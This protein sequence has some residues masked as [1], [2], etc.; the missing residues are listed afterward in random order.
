MDKTIDAFGR[1]PNSPCSLL[2]TINDCIPIEII[3]EQSCAKFI[4]QAYCTNALIH[5]D[6]D[7]IALSA[8]STISRG[9]STFCDNH[10]YFS[11]LT[12]IIV[13]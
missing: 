10:R 2:P 4:C 8:L 6:K 5:I 11:F 3:F 1:Y 7:Y 9:N 13:S 12:Y